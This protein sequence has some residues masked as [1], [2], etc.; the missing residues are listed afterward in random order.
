MN[1]TKQPRSPLIR[2]I[3]RK[4]DGRFTPSRRILIETIKLQTGLDMSKDAKK[5]FNLLDRWIEAE[6]KR[7]ATLRLKAIYH[8][9]L[10]SFLGQ[11]DPLYPFI[12]TKKGFPRSMYFLRKYRSSPEGIQAALGLLAYHRCLIAPGV[13]NTNPITD[14]GKEIPDG[15]LDSIVESSFQYWKFDPHELSPSTPL[16]RSK[17]GPNGQATLSACVDLVALK[18]TGLL[19]HLKSYLSHVPSDDLDFALEDLEG[20]VEFTGP[21]YTGR[22]SIKREGGGKDRVF[23][24]VDYWTQCALKPLHMKLAKILNTL[25]TDC[26]FN[27]GQGVPV[28]KEWSKNSKEN[29]SFD[30]SSA[31]DR[32]PRKLQMKLLQKLTD[33]SSYA[34]SWNDLMSDRD[35]YYKGKP[36]RWNV[37]Q[38]LGAYSSWP[39]FALTHH[40]VVIHAANVTN[41]EPSYFL[42]G[43][44]IVIQGRALAEKYK[45]ILQHLGVE[46]SQSKT[47]EG[48]A[49][50]FAKRLFKDG[51]EVTPVPVRMIQALTGDPLLIREGLNHTIDRSSTTSSDCLLRLTP[52]L[53]DYSVINRVPLNKVEVLI[54][55]PFGDGP[56]SILQG[57]NPEGNTNLWPVDVLPVIDI[58]KI[59][60]QE[61]CKHI[62][63][64]L[65]RQDNSQLRELNRWKSYPL[66]G[67]DSG[68]R[69]LHPGANGLSRIQTEHRNIRTKIAALE[70]SLEVLDPV[71]LPDVHTTSFSGLSP[72]FKSRRKHQTTVILKVFAKV[73][74]LSN[75]L[76]EVQQSSRPI[77]ESIV[78]HDDSFTAT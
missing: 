73:L 43:D 70:F 66:P 9:A 67:L 46:I 30:L 27:Q 52:Y 58:K 34:K 21:A 20:I 18:N 65:D 71:E 35:F 16:F 49:I 74:S 55:A 57:L 50:E 4:G 23:A 69:Y 5:V 14:Q 77:L 61:M 19:Q 36:Y 22:L 68:S 59:A 3:S 31:T 48:S 1:H 32:F 28:I 12:G 26:T 40:L 2:S 41:S 76:K 54:S 38:P 47:L 17:Q 63:E 6:G 11:S 15:Y 37:G 13:P 72:K 44:D 56:L 60:V 75:R 33:S 64:N 53:R 42:L 62:L 10:N 25:Q 7:S 45:E 39:M 78:T 51:N 8:I 24:M 29:F